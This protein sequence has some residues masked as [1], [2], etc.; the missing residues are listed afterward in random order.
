MHQNYVLMFILNYKKK[1]LC[2]ISAETCVWKNMNDSYAFGVLH[3]L[4]QRSGFL[5]AN[6]SIEIGL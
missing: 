1:H 2:K 5:D 6:E 3:V 4:Y